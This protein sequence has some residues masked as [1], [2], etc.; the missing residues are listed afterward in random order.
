[1]RNSCILRLKALGLYIFG[2]IW[3]LGLQ[4]AGLNIPEEAYKRSNRKGCS[5]QAIKSMLIKMYTFVFIVFFFLII[6]LQNI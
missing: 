1:M 4:T 6:K 3:G 2:R 5:K